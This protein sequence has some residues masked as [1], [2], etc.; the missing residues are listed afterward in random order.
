M[1]FKNIFKPKR[2]GEEKIRFEYAGKTK[3]GKMHGKGIL[4]YSNGEKYVGEFRDG[5]KHEKE[6]THGKAE[7][8]L[9]TNTLENIKMVKSTGKELTHL[10]ME[11]LIKVSGKT[12][13]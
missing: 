11:R 6:L 13:N 7:S 4:T 12:A 9:E 5:K 1:F 2:K 8:L 3:N 10:Q